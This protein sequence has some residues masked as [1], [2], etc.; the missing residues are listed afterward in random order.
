MKDPHRPAWR[1]P[2]LWLVVGLPLV[3][4]CASIVTIILASR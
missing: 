1:E 4:I 3:V 2:M